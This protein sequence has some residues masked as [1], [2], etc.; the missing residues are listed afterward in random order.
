VHAE[1]LAASEWRRR[2]DA[3]Q[4]RADALTAA[5]R[6]RK[7]SGERHPID[8]FLY[9]YYTVKPSLLRR[10]HPGPGIV[11]ATA[12]DGPAEHAAW[13]WYRAD[14]DGAV[15]LDVAAFLADRGGTVAHIR[16]LLSATAAR[17]AHTGCFGL[18]EWAMVYRQDDTRRRHS[19][20]L[21]LGREGTD[22]V[23]ESHPLRCTHFDAFRF[24]TPDAVPRNRDLLSR[25]TQVATEQPGCLHANMD[26]YKWALKLGPLVPGDLLLDCFELARE[27]RSTDMAASPYDVTT[28]GLAPIA[29]ETADGKA[30]YVR[31]Q[32]D[33]ALR[34]NA[35]RHR[36]LDVCRH[37]TPVQRQAHAGGGGGSHAGIRV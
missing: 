15:A 29:I 5:H 16:E 11:L 4:A 36:I 1:Q 27:I 37:I 2:A 33:H 26:L 32:R 35:L 10:W 17:P 30:E 8:D 14:G 6:A 25:D 21:R 9:D 22:A 3:H 7:A 12:E 34:S 31:R 13:R 28:Y 23:V 20:P 19:L 18:H 24:F